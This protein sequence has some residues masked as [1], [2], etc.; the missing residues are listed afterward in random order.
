MDRVFYANSR[1]K[2]MLP[3][4]F[5][6]QDAERLA[7]ALLG[8]VVRV[9]SAGLWLAVQII[10]TEAYYIHEK[11]SHASQGYTEKR[12]ALFMPPGTIYM[13]YSRA[14][15]SMNVSAQGE[16]NAVLIKSGIPY[17][18][19]RSAHEQ[20][21]AMQRLNPQ[22]NTKEPRNPKRLCAGQTLL[23]KSLGLTVK[24][25]DQKQFHKS[26]FYI[27]DV[28]YVPSK[29][30]KT[31]RLGIPE[32]RDEHLLYRYVDAKFADQCTQNPFRKEYQMLVL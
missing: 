14:G 31:A 26:K 25:W 8:K 13:Y 11:A 2:T 12:K 32:G 27:A 5:F 21:A 1:C 4:S 22:K 29:I 24:Q 6:D 10:E 7:I 15:D 3:Q 28:G 30:I 16:G 19:G 9:K 20:L 23:C 18:K 17:L